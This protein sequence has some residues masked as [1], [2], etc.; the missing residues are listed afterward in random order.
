MRGHFSD[1]HRNYP[2]LTMMMMMMKFFS[3]ISLISTCVVQVVQAKENI[4]TIPVVSLEIPVASAT[5]ALRS[6]IIIGFDDAGDIDLKDLAFSTYSNTQFPD[7][8][9]TIDV[10]VT[11]VPKE[12]QGQSSCDWATLAGVGVPIQQ[13]PSSTASSPSST[14]WFCC[15]KD[16]RAD[17]ACTAEQYGHLILDADKFQGEKKS[18]NVTTTTGGDAD[19]TPIKFSSE[20]G[21]GSWFFADHDGDYAI[22]FANCHAKSKTVT[23]HGNIIVESFEM[24]KTMAKL[25]TFHIILALAY[26]ALMMY[27]HQLMQMHKASRIMLEEWIMAVIGLGFLEIALRAMEFHVWAN[28]GDRAGGLAFV[29]MLFGAAKHALGRCLLLLLSLG[30]GVVRDSLVIQ[31]LSA[32]LFLSLALFVTAIAMDLIIF[33]IGHMS[34]VNLALMSMYM[35]LF[36]LQFII[37]TIFMIWIPCALRSTMKYLTLTDQ[38]VKKLARYRALMRIVVGC[39]L[40]SILTLVVMYTNLIPGIGYMTLMETNQ[41]SFFI[42]L[43]FVAMVWR[44]NPYAREYAYSSLMDLEGGGGSDNEG[45]HRNAAENAHG[46]SL[47]MELSDSTPDV[48]PVQ[49]QQQSWSHL[50]QQAWMLQPQQQQFS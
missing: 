32:V 17:K 24:K 1:S 16:A 34:D 30:W 5:Q 50:Q 35:T 4:T 37:E 36:R 46:S 47:Y 11:K 27:Y 20:D 15:T 23:V 43:T 12:C 8:V 31:T 19:R 13:G 28:S 18:I 38:P 26:I 41:V 25:S 39:I 6:P 44:P 10:V 7:H 42:I 2:R 45:N 40:L 9:T 22:M 49:L 21:S 48:A 33:S 29:A 3:L 14:S